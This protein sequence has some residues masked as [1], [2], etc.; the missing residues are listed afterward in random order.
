MPIVLTDV[1]QDASLL[2]YRQAF[3]KEGIRSIAF[4]PLM[5]DGGLIGKFVLY[6]NAPHEFQPEEIRV[7]QAIATAV[8]RV[9]ARQ[10]VEQA[11]RDSEERLLFAQGAAQ[12][13]VWDCDLRT[14][15][16]WISPEYAR[17]HG[18]APDHP[19]LTHEEW[20]G[21][22]HPGDRERVAA[23]LKE[24]IETTHLWDHEFRFVWPDGSVHWLLGKGKVFLDESH[25]PVRVTG[26][27]LDVTERR[28][29]E[30]KFSGLLESAPDA[31]VVTKQDGEIV[32]VNSQV[33]NLFGYRRDELLGKTIELLMPKR[34][35]SRHR[36]YRKDYFAQPEARPM[37]SGRELQGL[38]KDGTEFSVE[39][40]L[41]P[42]KT[43][44]ELLV[45][46]SIRD[47]T[48]RKRADDALRESEERFRRVFEEGP[49]GL[50]LVGKDY[51][52]VKVNSALC[53]MVGYS[54]A[55]LLQ[56][57]FAD[58]THPDDLQPDVELAERLFSGEMPFFKLR[59]RY[60]KKNGEVIWIDLTASL[61]HNREGEP[62]TG[63]AMIEDITERKRAEDA[64]RK[65]Q[66][67]VV[68]IYNTVEDI[69]FHLATEPEGQF[70][71]VSVN[72]AF[73]RVTGLSQEK[74]VGKTVNEVIPEPSLTMVLGKYRQAIEKHTVVHWEETSDY[75][76]GQLIGE[77]RVVPVFDNTG[78]CTHLVGS[79]HDITEVKRSQEIENRLRSDLGHSRDE[80]RALAASLMRAQED[81]RRRVSREL[82]DH[83]CHQLGS[84]DREI[85][86]LA[87]GPLPSKNVRAKLEEIRERVVKTSKETQHIAHQMHTAILDDLGLVASL[88]DLCSQFSEQ[89]PDIA[90]DFENSGLPAAIPDEVVFCLFRVA[91]ESLQNITKH[92]GAK[93]VSVCLRFKKRAVV[94]AIQD[95][96]AGFD[97]K[98]V[99]GRGK[100]G[101]VSMEERA[102]SV[103]GKLKITAQPGHGTQIAL[104]AP[105]PVG[106]S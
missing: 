70:R 78:T 39:I 83:I 97:A 48:E 49:L 85:S 40:S 38:R 72:A 91:E 50:A 106:N 35:R 61:I 54:E 63:L 5:A 31:M 62:T 93:N 43:D 87:A 76:A 42:L 37:G 30:E 67:Q 80:I 96:G 99:K 24:S 79:V 65:S 1:L 71:F 56:M 47:V 9:W 73:L 100:I 20:L 94:L 10:H 69:I 89:Y 28:S 88:K 19:P 45:S 81:E 77:V 55:S 58:I 60:V 22:V 32:L 16:T 95:D 17:I 7:S 8:A 57:S 4:I 27:T 75:P 6:Y 29:A 98:A 74:V 102:R 14:N 51:H 18:L 23:L 26:V 11:L 92:S 52:F 86:K 68:S 44:D 104:E 41:A 105:L 2:V 15:L 46:A 101:L 34:F 13:G 53:Q 64:L 12:V 3:V 33:E 21:M 36:S 84:L 82:H 66:Q 103:K 25:R 59:K 90:V